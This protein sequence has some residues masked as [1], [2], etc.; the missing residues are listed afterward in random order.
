[1]PDKSPPYLID[2]IFQAH[3]NHLLGGPSG[4]GKTRWLLETFA[5]WKRGQPIFGHNSH[6]APW[7]YVNSDRNQ[8]DFDAILKSLSIEPGE[9]PMFPAWDLRLGYNGIIDYIAKTQ[10]RLVVWEGFDH[11]AGDRANSFV[12]TNFLQRVSGD[13]LKLDFTV[14]GVN[15]RPKMNPRDRYPNPRERI[16]GPAAWAR[17]ASTIFLLE[18]GVESHPQDPSR[19]FFVCPRHD[20]AVEYRAAMT[21]EGRITILG[22]AEAAPVAMFS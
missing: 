16:S 11:L 7:L 6:P 15:E 1:M 4:A 14:L 9:V 3:Q 17:H 10:P 18:F 2:H 21:M 13:M 22:K 5:K 19:N 12:V 20:P 8:E